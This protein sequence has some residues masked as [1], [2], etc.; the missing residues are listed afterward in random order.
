MVDLL[1]NKEEFLKVQGFLNKKKSRKRYDWN[2]SSMKLMPTELYANKEIT[3]GGGKV[4][5]LKGSSVRL[6][7]TTNFDGNKLEDGRIAVIDGVAIHIAIGDK[8]KPSHSV[9]FTKNILPA[10]FAY[11]NLTLKQNDE[12]L[13]KL[14]ITSIINGNDGF[15]G[16]Y[17]DLGGYSL[18]LDKHA[19]ELEIEFPDD[20]VAPTLDA[21][22]SIHVST[23][24]RGFETYIKR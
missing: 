10:A 17:R 4:A 3:V 12:V 1:S 7:G 16:K 15:D 8:N 14:P 9:D 22:K 18:V 2:I 11:A 13:I 21:G 24:F 23:I 19:V 6:T 20:V 5:L